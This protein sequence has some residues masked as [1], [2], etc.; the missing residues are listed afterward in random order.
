MTNLLVPILYVLAAIGAGLIG[1]LFFAFS[2]FIMQALARVPAQS[3]AAA[4]QSI[5]V[6]VL[7]PLF[8][9]AFFGTGVIC[10]ILAVMA[11][12]TR[13]EPSSIACLAAAIIYLVGTIG[14]TMAFNVPLNEKLAQM[15]LSD[16]GLPDLWSHYLAEW[17]K[18]NHVR[19]VASLLAAALFM[20]AG[21]L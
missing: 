16:P 19:A 17:T 4:M 2:N 9:A 20:V 6:T 3:G 1:G 13:S 12:P 11:L 5:N 15:P 7:N 14:V 10:L 8:F 18:W 21:M